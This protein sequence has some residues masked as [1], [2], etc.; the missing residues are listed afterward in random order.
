MEEVQP[1]PEYLRLMIH[2]DPQALT[3]M[4][5]AETSL[6]LFPDIVWMEVSRR[7]G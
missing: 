3:G 2:F 4:Q 5:A 1:L 7:G 6:Q